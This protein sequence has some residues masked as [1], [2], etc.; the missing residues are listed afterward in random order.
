M[1]AGPVHQEK[2]E[3]LWCISVHCL[4]SC[5][6]VV[7]NKGLLDQNEQNVDVIDKEKTNTVAS[8]RK[9]ETSTYKQTQHNPPF[10]FFFR[11]FPFGCASKAES[12]LVT[13][14]ESKVISGLGIHSVNKKQE[15]V[16]RVRWSSEL[17]GIPPHPFFF[18]SFFF[19]MLHV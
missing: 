8:R 9:A 10:S 4:R 13:C 19:D 18:V 17:A 6:W 5:V 7:S 14:I 2:A 15:K 12:T 16:G 1:G 11:L 3:V